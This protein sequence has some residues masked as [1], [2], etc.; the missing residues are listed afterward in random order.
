LSL[1]KYN[2][3]ALII[4]ISDYMKMDS[5]DFCKNDGN[6]MY[7]IL[8]SKSV[9][10]N[11]PDS[12]RLIGQVSY[13]TLRN[14]IYDFF[15]SDNSTP[16]DILLFYYSG[17]GIPGAGG[18]Y[19][20]SSEID[21]DKPNRNGFS[22]SELTNEANSCNSVRMVMIL[23]C[24]HSGTISL[25]KGDENNRVKIAKE[26]I[27]KE[28]RNIQQGQGKFILAA[29]QGYQEAYLLQEK[30]HSIFT[31][32]LLKGIKGNKKSVDI[33]GNVTPES[34]TKYISREI[35]NF[36][37]HKRLNQIPVMKSEA[38]GDVI[39]ASYSH[40]GRMAKDRRDR[41]ARMTKDRRDR[42]ARMTKDRRDGY[43]NIIRKTYDGYISYEV[44]TLA[45]NWRYRFQSNNVLQLSEINSF[46][47]EF[48]LG[49]M[50]LW[51]STLYEKESGFIIRLSQI[52]SDL[53][54]QIVRLKN[55]HHGIDYTSIN[56]D[57]KERIIREQRR[58]AKTINKIV[59]NQPP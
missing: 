50:H 53:V 34:L 46:E 26:R 56:R 30:G 24:C 41:L 12:H 59:S 17:H 32:Y 13:E 36:S 44:F 54:P 43:T 7:D 55:M 28:S 22:F 1:Q 8:T 35:R 6:A 52:I 38:S 16:D 5:L 33:Y 40:L 11:I 58:I 51:L 29:S 14:A 45:D 48:I 4:A 3:K 57:R 10:F 49:K 37:D 47:K 21:S 31:Y 20:A 23:D 19:L 2:K 39:L 27:D 42:L 25:T 18:V 9:G 15:D